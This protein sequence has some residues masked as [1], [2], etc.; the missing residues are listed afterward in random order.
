MW[1]LAYFRLRRETKRAMAREMAMGW[2]LPLF[3]SRRCNRAAPPSKKAKPTVGK[4]FLFKRRARAACALFLLPLS[5]LIL[6]PSSSSEFSPRLSPHCFHFQR[7]RKHIWRESALR[8]NEKGKSDRDRFT[9]PLK[10][11]GQRRILRNRYY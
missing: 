8:G 11:G 1:I 9:T 2:V 7:L 5:S 3:T 6:F 4:I 10:I